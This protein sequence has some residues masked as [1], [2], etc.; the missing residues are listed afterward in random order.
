MHQHKHRYA[1]RKS[2]RFYICRLVSACTSSS[3]T[4]TTT[5]AYTTGNL[6]RNRRYSPNT[7]PLAHPDHTPHHTQPL[8]HPAPLHYLLEP[9]E[10]VERYHL[11]LDLEQNGHTEESELTG[12]SEPSLERVSYAE[13]LNTLYGSSS[14]VGVVVVEYG[15]VCEYTERVVVLLRVLH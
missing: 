13:D 4:T 6:A 9:V 3:S 7:Q 12:T 11:C 2:S 1:C 15:G 14:S 5:I 10:H 8:A